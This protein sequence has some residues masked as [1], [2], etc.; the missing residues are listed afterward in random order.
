MSNIP[1]LQRPRRCAGWGSVTGPHTHAPAYTN[2]SEHPMLS[3]RT[4]LVTQAELGRELLRHLA[5]DG[6][7]GKL[8][9][10]QSLHPPASLGL[11][12]A[13]SGC[14]GG[15][16]AW[17]RTGAQRPI[18]QSAQTLR[19]FEFGIWPLGWQSLWY[20]KTAQREKGAGKMYDYW[21]GKGKWAYWLNTY[22]GMHT[23]VITII[24]YP[25]DIYGFFRNFIVV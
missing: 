23:F 15:T 11:L 12:V 4:I 18:W 8:S 10:N 9:L 13:L 22:S 24:N 7:N 25:L 20:C 5:W 2:R 19:Q 6:G 16:R 21:F 1:L 14:A 17:P 3:P